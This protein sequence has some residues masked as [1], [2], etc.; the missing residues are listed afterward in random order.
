MRVS[1][2]SNCLRQVSLKLHSFFEQLQRALQRQIAALHFLDDRFELLESGLEA[3]R[4]LLFRHLS[5]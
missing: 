4:R 2:S 3:G 5:F 1:A